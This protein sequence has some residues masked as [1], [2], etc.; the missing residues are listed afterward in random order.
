[1]KKVLLFSF[2]F[3]FAL[4]TM[5]QN[6][7]SLLQESFNSTTIPAG[8]SAQDHTANWSISPTT[9][10]GGAANELRLYYD[11]SFN[12]TTHFMSPT[13]DLTGISSVIVNFKHALD[14]YSGGHTLGI[15]TS[16]DGGTTWNTGWSQTYSSN[17]SW[18]V[19]Q[20]ISTS[21]MGKNNVNFCIFYT[22]NVYNINNWYF[23]DIKVFTL[24]NLDLSL[25]AINVPS[26]IGCGVTEMSMNVSNLGLTAITSIEASY[27]V[28]GDGV[29]TTVTETINVNIPSLGKATV[30]FDTPTTLIPGEYDLTFEIRKVNGTDDDIAANNSLSTMVS[31]SV[32]TV[33]K[34]PMIEHFSSSTCGPCVNVNT[35]MQNFCNNNPGRFTY[36]KYQMNWPGNGDPYYTAEGGTRRT[37]YGVSAVPQVFLDGEDQGYAAVQTTVFNQHAERDAFVDIRGSFTMDGSTINVKVDI[38]PF[39]TTEARV[40]VSVNEKETHN[41]VGGNGETSFH[42]V[43]MKMLPN[44]QG[45]TQNFVSGEMQHMDFT[46]DM[47]GTHVE[48]M[49]DLEVSI[50][51]QNFTSK[52]VFNSHFAYEYTDEHPY[53]VENLTMVKNEAKDDSMLLSW[54]VPTYGNPVGYN[55]YINGELVSEAT[56]ETSYTFDIDPNVYYV[57]GVTALYADAKTSVITAVVQPEEVVDN[58]LVAVEGEVALTANEPS[59]ELH[60]MNA[61]YESL[62]PIEILSIVEAENETG[63]PYLVITA[64]QLPYTLEVGETYSF[65]IEPN[66]PLPAKSVAEAIIDVA[67]DDRIVTFVVEIDGDLLSVTELSAETKL[68]PNPTSG[69]FTVE[70]L[71]VAKV[72]VYNLVGQ[73]VFEQQGN[74]VVNIDA[75]GW[76]KGLYLLNITNENGSIETK[77]LVVK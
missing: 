53:P 33:A 29:E 8:W 56:T 13:V 59:A 23:D 11:P 52:E 39:I 61:N 28:Q 76:N 58:G 70:G 44:A 30:S 15:A 74:K 34:I 10:A 26:F 12:G 71:N 22:G 45:L 3:L 50:W 48:E 36:T 40:Y 20:E 24:E 55:V 75:S 7:A 4:A 9:N 42:H 49:S 57:A 66:Y 68:Y 63:V 65:M 25:D 67:S 31:A 43:F 47:S 41:N 64:E 54:D 17:G 77:K 19:M 60:V 5:A 27:T 51:V 46:H 73:K 32:Y 6:R 35:Q 21:D 38:M 14:N 18:E 62:T 37:Y 2:A 1:M 69:T 72:E 16:S